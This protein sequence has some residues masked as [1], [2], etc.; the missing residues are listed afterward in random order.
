MDY[1]SHVAY[2]N[3][4]YCQF[5]VYCSCCTA[6]SCKNLVWILEYT[7]TGYIKTKKERLSK[8]KKKVQRD[9]DRQVW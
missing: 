8:Q 1:I 7:L 2:L 9:K 6:F 5:W 3:C 4:S